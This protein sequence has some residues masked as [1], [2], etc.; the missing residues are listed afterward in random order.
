MKWIIKLSYLL[1]YLGFCFIF[2]PVLNADWAEDEREARRK[3]EFLQ[4][5]K[6]WI[7][8]KIRKRAKK[9]EK[10]RKSVVFGN[11]RAV[12]LIIKNHNR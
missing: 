9:L 7:Y 4:L 3:A 10:K 5:E 12:Q 6:D 2:W 1:K 8:H 11:L